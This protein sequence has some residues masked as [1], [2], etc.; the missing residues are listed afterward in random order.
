[1]ADS[2]IKI[3][4]KFPEVKGTSSGCVFYG[5]FKKKTPKFQI[6]ECHDDWTI[7]W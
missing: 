2:D 7:L 1:M 3:H 6:Q 5:I 4:A